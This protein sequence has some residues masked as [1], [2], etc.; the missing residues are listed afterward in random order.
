MK[1]ILTYIIN[2]ESSYI[3]KQFMN[4][5]LLEYQSFDIQFIDAIDGRCFSKTQRIA[6]FD[7]KL[8]MKR[9]GRLLNGGELGCV[10]SHRKC[11]QTLLST[12]NSYALILEDDVYPMRS[13]GELQTVDLDGILNVDV[14]VI[15]LLSGDYWYY[16]RKT[17]VDVYDAIGAYAYFVNRAAASKILSIPKPYNVAD[18]WALYKRYGIKLKAIYPYL[19]DANV[20]MDLLGSDVLQDTWGSKKNKMSKINLI[21][22]IKGGIL[23]RIFSYCGHFESKVRIINNKI[24]SK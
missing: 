1:Q 22:A 24:V 7:D 10:L 3:R 13:L 23:K 19:V 5:W 8:C 14:P 2:L 9:Y 18:D 12:S 21:R 20:N 17:V 11:Y 16:K 15:L 6:V 4:D